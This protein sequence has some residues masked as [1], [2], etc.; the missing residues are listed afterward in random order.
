MLIELKDTDLSK[1]DGI[2]RRLSNIIAFG[3][4]VFRQLY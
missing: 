4:R 3:I 2:I 1:R